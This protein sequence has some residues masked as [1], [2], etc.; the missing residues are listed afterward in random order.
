MYHKEYSGKR[1]LVYYRG[2]IV[3]EEPFEDCTKDDP[4]V[5]EIGASLVPRG[6]E[7]LLYSMDIGEKKQ[8]VIPCDKAYGKHDPEGV[9]RY[10]RSFLHNGNALQVGDVFA[11]NHP[12]SKKEVP[13]QCIEATEHM[14][15]IDFNHFLAGKDLNYWFELIDV[16]DNK[17]I[18]LKEQ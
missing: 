10:L 6:I 17:G 8:A 9:Q 2:G 15:T 18:S 13:V 11:W 12:V 3:G 16:I 5:I 1:A 14:V 4:V 7:E